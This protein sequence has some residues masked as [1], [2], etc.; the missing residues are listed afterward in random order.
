[1]KYLFY[2][3]CTLFIVGCSSNDDVYLHHEIKEYQGNWRDTIYSANNIY[4]EDLTIK[5]YSIQYLLF[6]AVT[7]VVLD[8]LSGTIVVGNENKIGWN[9]FCPINNAIRQNYWDVLDLSPYQMTLYSNTN[10]VRNYKRAHY[11]TIEEKRMQDKL[12]NMVRDTLKEILQY[13]DYLPL[14]KNDLIEKFG[15]YNRLVSCNG[16]AYFTHHPLFEKISFTENFDN[17]SIYSYTLFINDWNRCVQKVKSNFIK[18]RDVDT[19]TE[20]IDSETLETAD[21]VV[22]VDSLSRQIALKPIKDYDYW[23]NVSH[24]LGKNLRSFKDVFRANYVYEYQED[25]SSGL[26]AYKFLSGIDSICSNIFVI[27]DSTD[28]IRRS[29]VSMLKSF[30]NSKKKEAQKEL[31]SYASLLNRKYFLNRTTLDDNGNRIYYYYPCQDAKEATYEIRLM[32]AQYNLNNVT[33]TYQV[34]VYYVQ[35]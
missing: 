8:T 2:I 23:P 4:V 34:R 33:K 1:M 14:H 20:Y 15:S 28:I 11:S 7:Y 5:D 25:N 21:N 24:Y 30:I 10:G 26:R 17:D 29:G 12:Q 3:I 13:Q 9:C 16:I 27:V 35:L 31:D 19:T 32:L 18:L 6:N 22:V